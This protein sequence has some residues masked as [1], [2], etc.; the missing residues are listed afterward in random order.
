MYTKDLKIENP[1][2]FQRLLYD[3]SSSIL[4]GKG[5]YKSGR[6]SNIPYLKSNGI[7]NIADF[8]GTLCFI[9]NHTNYNLMSRIFGSIFIVLGSLLVLANFF[10]YFLIDYYYVVGAVAIGIGL[11]LLFK[12]FGKELCIEITLIGESYRTDFKKK[13][14]FIE[15]LNVRSHARLT[16]QGTTVDPNQILSNDDM[17]SL[18]TDSE[19]LIIAMN[20]FVEK[21]LEKNE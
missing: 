18:K 21:Y 2:K 8:G 5:Y 9:K 17:Y 14:G 16:I 12:K 19:P 4:F 3:V 1:K 10:Q 13:E 11:I 15:Y 6:L 7:E 20:S